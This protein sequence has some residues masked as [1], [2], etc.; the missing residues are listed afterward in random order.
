MYAYV[1]YLEKYCSCTY[2]VVYDVISVHTWCISSSI[3]LAVQQAYFMPKSFHTL[4]GT[5]NLLSH[6]VPPF[7]NSFSQLLDSE[8]VTSYHIQ[9]LRFQLFF[10]AILHS[11]VHHT[12]T[13]EFEVI[14]GRTKKQFI[15][16]QSRIYSINNM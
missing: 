3:L 12:L 11:R 13:K 15:L 10:L 7:S 6:I 4:F 2:D 9:C 14:V 5:C 16:C 8:H 1:L